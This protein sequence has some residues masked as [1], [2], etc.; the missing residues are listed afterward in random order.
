MTQETTYYTSD[1]VRV[2]NSRAILGAKTYAMANITS[3]SM[4]EIPANRTPG[5]V[6]AGLG[7]VG[8]FVGA[9][10]NEGTCI[11]IA[12]LLLILGIVLA[13][14]VKTQYS[15]RLGSSSGESD[16]LSSPDQSHIREIVNAMN[17]AIINRG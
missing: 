12:V 8:L 4:G 9:G 17:E 16:A 1:K 10:M 6:L 5:I 2:T 11:G 3:V 13:L 14:L 7:V 15:V